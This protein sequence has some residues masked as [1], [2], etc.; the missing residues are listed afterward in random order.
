MVF[1]SLPTAAALM[2][3]MFAG[4]RG[5]IHLARE[6]PSDLR[7]AAEVFDYRIQDQSREIDMF[8]EELKDKYA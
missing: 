2:V 1:V 8:V 6:F 4:M 7:E 5:A 3:G